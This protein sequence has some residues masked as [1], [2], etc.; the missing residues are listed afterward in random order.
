MIGVTEDQASTVSSPSYGD[1][2]DDTSFSL[3]S[4]KRMTCQ[5]DN[6]ENDNAEEKEDLSS[7]SHVE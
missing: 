5:D 1:D 4:K 2:E 3:T 7:T 6:K